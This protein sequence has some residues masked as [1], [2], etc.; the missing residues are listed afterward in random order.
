MEHEMKKIALPALA[1]AVAFVA[2]P[3]SSA[4]ADPVPG[5]YIGGGGIYHDTESSDTHFNHN[6]N[7]VEFDNGWGGEGSAGY[8]FDSGFRLEGEAAYLR[9]DLDKI[10]G[11]IGG[12]HGSLQ[13]TDLTLNALYDFH[14]GTILTPYIGMGGGLDLIN[15]SGIGTFADG[16][17][18]NDNQ[19]VFVWQAIVGVA[20]QIDQHWA[21]TADYR[22]I[23]TT[24]PR[25]QSSSGNNT[26]MEIASHNIVVGVRYSF[27]KPQ[28][29]AP[30]EPVATPVPAYPPA[31]PIVAAVPQ[32][33]MVF[34]DFNK[35]TLTPEAKRIIAAA[36][37][38]F[39]NGGYVRVVVTGHTDTVGTA[40]YN[41][42]L[43]ERRAAA[44]KAEFERLGVTDAAIVANGVG[45]N[46]LLVPTANGVR[47]AQNRRAEIVLDKQ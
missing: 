36:A 26:T 44:V 35:D 19:M 47:E 28:P 29:P 3:F 38:D 1:L 11:G 24:D 18:L 25:F 23:D 34:F 8:E 20:A 14:T 22:F 30:I 45:K 10:K 12:A 32:S 5:W 2:A 17:T 27:G 31:K 41:Q 42:K 15:A 46:G 16:G 9:S 37:Q 7:E 40:S 33:Y 21:V 6:K 4:Q 39:H 13:D 43:S